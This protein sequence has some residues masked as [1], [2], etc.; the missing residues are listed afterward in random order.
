MEAI[1][2]TDLPQMVPVESSNV[3]S[4]G[5][6]DNHLY[7]TYKNGGT[8]RWPNAAAEHHAPLMAAESKGRYLHQMG[9]KGE[10]VG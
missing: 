2:S 10:R 6:K 1:M 9:L 7:V 5:H 3:A 4:V 8:Y